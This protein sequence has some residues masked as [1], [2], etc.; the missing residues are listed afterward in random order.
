MKILVAAAS[1]HGSTAEVGQFLAVTLI[2]AGHEAV[3]VAPEGVRSLDGFDAAIIGSAVYAGHWLEPAKALVARELTVLA[4]MPVWLFSSGPIGDPAKPEGDPVDL[5]A[6]HSQIRPRGHRV[7]AGRIDRTRLSLAEK[8]IASVL[9]VPEGDYRPWS[10][11][12]AWSRQIAEAL[13]ARDGHPV[14]V[15]ASATPA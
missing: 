14:L 3:V 7:F 11:I 15:S 4:G 10:T 13:H 8:A 2:E 1:K 6:L 5:A 12:E 9:R